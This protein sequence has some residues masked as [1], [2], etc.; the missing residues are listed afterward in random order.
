[1]KRTQCDGGWK[2]SKVCISCGMPMGKDEDF[3]LQDATKDYCRFCAGA[4]GE[5]QSYDE[6]LDGMT[7]FI[8]RTQGFD[9]GAARETARSMMSKPPAWKDR[10]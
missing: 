8:V 5:L 9:E 7:S 2:M 10:G 4:N 1:M 3:A 6:R